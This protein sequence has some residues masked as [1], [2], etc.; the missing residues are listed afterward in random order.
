MENSCSKKVKS[1]L[2]FWAI[3]VVLVCWFVP[4][5]LLIY[6]SIAKKLVRDF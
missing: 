5:N 4:T 3:E 1:S 2:K 6:P